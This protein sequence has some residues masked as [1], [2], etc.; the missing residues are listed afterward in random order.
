MK[1]LL[2]CSLPEYE[3]GQSPEKR[4]S[5]ASFT[6]I[7]CSNPCGIF[8]SYCLK[9]IAHE[10]ISS[11]RIAVNDDGRITKDLLSTDRHP[12]DDFAVLAAITLVKLALASSDAG[13]E[14]LKSTRVSYMLQAA[15]LLE[16]AWTHSKSNFQI[17]LILIRLYVYLGCGSLAMRSFQRLVLKQVQLDTL[18]YILFD[19]ISSFHPHPFTHTPDGTTGSRTPIEQLRKHQRLYKSAQEHVNKNVWLSFKHNS[20]NSVFEIKEVEETLS[21]SLARVMSVIESKKVARLM[22]PKRTL[23][24]IYQEFDI[25]GENHDIFTSNWKLAKPRL[26]RTQDKRPSSYT[27]QYK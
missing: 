12:A 26:L 6:C 5:E 16:N 14:P 11:Y 13:S 4:D 24:E 19:R 10:S 25:L 15:V 2:R 23:A 20:Y 27:R 22:E 8:C 17:S 9:A 3:R 21:R 7:S 18:S 1:Y